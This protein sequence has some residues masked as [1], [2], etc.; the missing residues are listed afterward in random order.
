ML[1]ASPE[2][3]DFDPASD[4]L[5]DVS[6]E[7]PAVAAA[8]EVLAPDLKSQGADEQISSTILI[9][10]QL[11]LDDGSVQMVHVRA[12]DRCKEVSARF[13]REHSLKQWFEEPLT[14]FL[15]QVE[16]DADKFPV[17]IEADLMEIRRQYSK[18]AA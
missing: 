18:N 3:D 13:V 15:K 9:E 16:D 17:K 14:K 2:D 1:G 11:T 8:P 6:T 12:A 7:E 5:V 10:A 4:I